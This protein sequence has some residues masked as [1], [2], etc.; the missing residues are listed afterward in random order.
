MVGSA[1]TPSNLAMAK[2]KIVGYSYSAKL[3]SKKTTAWNFSG[4]IFEGSGKPP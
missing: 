4:P 1:N 3:Q 2:S